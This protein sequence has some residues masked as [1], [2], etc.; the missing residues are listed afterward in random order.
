[1]QLRCQSELE[2]YLDIQINGWKNL[3]AWTCDQSENLLELNLRDFSL[4]PNGEH[5][6]Q[7]TFGGS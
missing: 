6:R 1:M 7:C 2:R 4:A 3:S 5:D